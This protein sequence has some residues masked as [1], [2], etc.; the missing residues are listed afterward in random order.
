MDAFDPGEESSVHRLTPCAQDSSAKGMPTTTLGGQRDAG[1]SRTAVAALASGVPSTLPATPRVREPAVSGS[2]TAA[3]GPGR[4]VPPPPSGSTSGTRKAPNRAA[5][6]STVHTMARIASRAMS[7]R[8]DLLPGTRGPGRAPARSAWQ[9]GRGPASASSRPY[10]P[11]EL[12][13]AA[14][15]GDA[16]GVEEQRLAAAEMQFRDSVK[17]A[18]SNAPTIIPGSP[19]FAGR[20]PALGAAAG[21][22]AASWWS[23]SSRPALGRTRSMTT[24]QNRSVSLGQQDRVQLVQ[25]VVR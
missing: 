8:G 14:G 24:V 13:G 16:V 9:V 6:G 18:A 22:A 12:A 20:R 7:S 1:R 15:L 19:T 10:L 17:C 2:A 23:P 25:D 5:R 11:E 4:R 21:V 3:Q